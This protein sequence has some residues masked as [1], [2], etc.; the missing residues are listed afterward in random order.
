M[1]LKTHLG[2]ILQQL[3]DSSW[4]LLVFSI[5]R[6]SLMKKYS[7]FDSEL[8]V[9]YSSLHHFRFMLEGREFTSFTDHKPLTNALIR[10]S[11]PWSALQLH[12]PSYLAEFTS[13]I[14]HVPGPEN[15]VV[16]ALSW[17]SSTPSPSPLALVSLFSP[18]LLS[19]TPFP[20]SS[21]APV[22]LVLMY[23][24]CLLPTSLKCVLHLPSLWFL[25]LAEPGDCFVTLLQVLYDLWFLFSFDVNSSTSS[26]MPPIVVF[27]PLRD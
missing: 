20:P 15:V 11:L 22:I 4:A 17:P 5:P 27:E 18:C 24:S 2:A 21:N 25:F 14:V 8:L 3:L 1:L 9:A 12:H 19:P 13:S 7:A 26:M 10:V 6:S 23:L 16:D